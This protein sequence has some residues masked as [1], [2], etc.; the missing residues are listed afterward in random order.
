MILRPA[1]PEDC[2]ALLAIYRPYVEETS[3]SFETEPPAAAEFCDRIVT[4]SEKFPYLV[5]EEQGEILG[6]A[7]AHPFHVRAAY[8]WTVETSIYV[9]QNRRGTHVGTRLYTALLRLL[10]LQGVKT[11]CAVV[12]IPN[13]P[14]LEFHKAMGF[15]VSGVMPDF[16]FKLGQW[17]PVGY[18]TLALGE[19]TV[20]PQPVIPMPQLPQPLVAQILTEAAGISENN[21]CKSEGFVIE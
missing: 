6:Y 19:K 5:A 13:E 11:A 1:L 12:T 4:F 8:G 10:A 7:Y 15:Q 3:V 14:S 16:G 20:P 18:L 21:P 2:P 17:H 9:A